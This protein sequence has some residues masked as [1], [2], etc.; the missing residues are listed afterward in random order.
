[1][2]ERNLSRIGA[3]SGVLSVFVT[4]VGFGVHGGLPS[5]TTTAA[6]QSYVNGVIAGQT[7]AGNYLELLGYLLFL[8]FAAYLYAVARTIGPDRLHFLNVL[9][10]TAATTYVA[11]SA[12]AI[13]A[14]Q[15]IV[16]SSSAGADVKSLL[17]LYIVDSE[18]FT[19]SFEILA[20]FAI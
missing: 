13:G 9:A 10:V 11:V 16:E 12:L 18:A 14:Q 8:V 17:T 1:M 3:A 15:A 19:L 20:L 4:F 2:T 6:I 5:A 7:G